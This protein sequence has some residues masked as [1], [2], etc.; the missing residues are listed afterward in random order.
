[1]ELNVRIIDLMLP[2]F[3]ILQFEEVAFHLEIILSLFEL[4]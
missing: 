3:S 2:L 1:M 4:Q